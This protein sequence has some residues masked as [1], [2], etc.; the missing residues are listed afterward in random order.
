MP[1]TALVTDSTSY[2]P[3]GR[4][5]A[6]D[7]LVVALR[8]LLDG[9]D[10]P[11]PEVDPAAFTARLRAGVRAT[12]SQPSPGA[13]LA[14][15]QAAAAGGADRVLCVTCTAAMSG[16]HGSAVLAAGM[17]ELP[18]DVVDSG[19]ISGGLALVVGELARQRELG[20]DHAELLAL[21]R[22]MAGRVRST[23][24]A[25]TSAL[26]AA[27]GRFTDKVPDGVPVLA[28]GP[29]GVR[30]LGAARAADEAVQLQAEVVR[31]AAAASP[32]WVTVGHTDVPQ[33]AEALEAA[34]TGAPGVLGVQRYVVGPVVAAHT[35]PGSVG[36]NYLAVPD[37]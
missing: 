29:D 35:G 16:T 4:A 19:T 34:L 9:Q 26:L 15:F 17:A 8:V 24:S 32:T 11:E 37:G 2:L 31:S 5:A 10:Q 22:S 25:D 6:L 18:V 13:F 28:L 7:V 1:R 21:A 36:A 33:L 20:A 27:G 23:W 12:T 3:P 30:A 14:A